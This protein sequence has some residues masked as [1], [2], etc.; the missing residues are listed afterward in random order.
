MSETHRPTNQL[1]QVWREF[2][3]GRGSYATYPARILVT[4][5]LWEQIPFVEYQEMQLQFPCGRPTEAE[6]EEHLAQCQK[7]I[8]VYDALNL[9]AEWRDLPIAEDS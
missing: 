4:Q 5:R 7:A 3:I 1:R 2:L 9:K 8:A 6:W